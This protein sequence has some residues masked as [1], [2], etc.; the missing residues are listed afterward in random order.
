MSS[1]GSISTALSAL[2]A[3]RLALDVTGHNIANVNT[4]GY[5]RQRVDLLPRAGAGAGSV[6]ANPLLAGAGVQVA[7]TSRLGDEFLTARVRSQTSGHA[8][9]QA[10][11]QTMVQV[12]RLLSEPGEEGLSAQLGA[13]WDA[14]SNLAKFPAELSAKTGLIGK[15]QDVVDA[16]RAGHASVE[17][18]WN[19]QH[20]QATALVVEVDELTTQIAGLNDA[21]LNTHGSGKNELLD[22]RDQLV[23]RLVE[24]TGATASPAAGGVLNV[25]LGGNPLVVGIRATAV[26]LSGSAS[27]AGVTAPVSPPVPL[28]QGPVRLTWPDGSS[29]GALRGG[30]LAG[31]LD[32]LNTT[33]PGVG[34]RYDAVAASLVS[35]VNGVYAG[36][37]GT[38]AP[39]VPSTFFDDTAPVTAATLALAPG[40]T[41]GSL[42]AG[43]LALGAKDDS[44]ALSMA[45]LRTAGGGPDATWGAHV[46]DIGVR[47]QAAT[48]RAQV[49][50]TTLGSAVA[51]HQ[52][53]VA[54][55]L[56]EE[57]ANLLVVQRAYE[58]A[59]RV[60]TAVDQ[61]LD[62]L[63][64]RTGLVGR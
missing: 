30:Q 1:F 22:Q 13:M 45:Q 7:G 59:A 61:A 14:W 37:D 58:G 36:V 38:P 12:E 49:A 4:P 6:L 48:G 63:I 17:T 16:V 33:L 2:Q 52:S 53:A 9:L 50:A 55:S 25:H 62:T 3:H 28:T 5:T 42:R 15:S 18:L 54:V 46:V 24:L 19:D 32:A 57:T 34:Q 8:D 20:T 60:L 43:P 10:K 39:A 27:M 29:V 26:A 64:N 23:T 47:T 44:V 31:A 41:V 56:D 21:V 35:T 51:D 11:A 40:L